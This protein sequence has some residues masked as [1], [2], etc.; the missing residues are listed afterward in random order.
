MGK[1]V[2]YLIWLFLL[3]LFVSCRASRDMRREDWTASMDSTIASSERL[4]RMR[5]TIDSTT[6]EMGKLTITEVIFFGPDEL[7]GGG[8]RE[9]DAHLPALGDVKGSIKEIRQTVIERGVERNGKSE[10]SGEGEER[11]RN[12]ELSMRQNQVQRQES[13]RPAAFDSRMAFCLAA[14]A[15]ALLLYLKRVPIVDWI[16]KI[17]AGL[18]KVI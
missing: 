12:A 9:G 2:H 7:P 15:I 6:V 17:L 14:V 16:K 11:H 3:F 18:R 8:A 10:E 1:V 13:T 5:R 4:S